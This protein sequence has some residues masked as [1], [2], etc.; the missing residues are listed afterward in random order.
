MSESD[1]EWGKG[2]LSGS[3]RGRK[4]KRSMTWWPK[5]RSGEIAPLSTEP[6]VDISPGGLHLWWT[7]WP[8]CGVLDSLR[9]SH[10][11]PC[12]I[13]HILEH[14]SIKAGGMLPTCGQW[15]PF[16]GAWL[17][18]LSVDS[19]GM[20]CSTVLL[21]LFHTSCPPHRGDIFKTFL[22]FCFS[23]LGV[24]FEV[25]LVYLP[26]GKSLHYWEWTHSPRSYI[27]FSSNH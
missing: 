18:N 5:V 2:V 13:G 15:K 1:M 17:S 25:N 7:R 12:P 10:A 26:A 16:C 6:R 9:G 22:K 8:W 3:S 19:F 11:G 23:S 4:H 24:C 27:S 21:S 14:S 20:K